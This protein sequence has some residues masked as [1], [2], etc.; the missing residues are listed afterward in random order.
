MLSSEKDYSQIVAWG[1]IGALS[2]NGL[3]TV[4][5]F[6]CTWYRPCLKNLIFAQE[7]DTPQLDPSGDTL[8]LLRRVTHTLPYNRSFRENGITHAMD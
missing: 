5:Q 2:L 6:K 4:W 3:T 8:H 1:F 7:K